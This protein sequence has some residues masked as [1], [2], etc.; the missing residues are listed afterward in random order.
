MYPRDVQQNLDIISLLTHVQSAHCESESQGVVMLMEDDFEWCPMSMQHLH[1]VLRLFQN[2]STAPT[3]VRV[4]FGLNGLLLSCSN[5]HQYVSYMRKNMFYG[6]AD[7]MLSLFYRMQNADGKRAFRMRNG[8]R[9]MYHAY[10]LNL[11]KHIGHQ[12]TLNSHRSRQYWPECF[13]VLI[14]TWMFPE[15]EFR[16]Q[17]TENEDFCPPILSQE[18]DTTSSLSGLL[19]QQMP[20]SRLIDQPF[21]S[22]ILRKGEA[23]ESCTKVCDRENSSRQTIAEKVDGVVRC[24]PELLPLLNNCDLLKKVFSCQTCG[25]FDDIHVIKGNDSQYLRNPM[26]YV[27][28][29]PP[30]PAGGA[31]AVSATPKSLHCDGA[32]KYFERLCPCMV[33]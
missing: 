24:A 9:P 16:C 26:H 2:S 18:Q 11:M 28:A 14:G 3:A 7:S 12:S 32:Y 19:G 22:I 4:S 31:C 33:F 15:D 29:H 8:H 21:S 10:R 27:G 13:N 5:I 20:V 23:G 30:P 6:P 17:A 25:V 1:R